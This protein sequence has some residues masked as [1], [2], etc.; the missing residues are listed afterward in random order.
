V[1]YPAQPIP[2]PTEPQRTPGFIE[3]IRAEGWPV[4]IVVILLWELYAALAAI[5]TLACP[6]LLL[7][8]QTYTGFPAAAYY[9]ATAV[10]FS[11]GFYGLFYR[12]LWAKWVIIGYQVLSSVMATMFAIIYAVQPDQVLAGLQRLFG[13]LPI[14]F[15]EP[16]LSYVYMLVPVFTW[17][18]TI[19]ISGYLLYKK[20][21]FEE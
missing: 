5:A 20:S 2:S 18:P 11:A 15:V 21:W 19:L 12:K 16:I 13:Q 7:G 17:I 4:G 14:E 10:I 9:M 8:S 1:E 3:R 6:R